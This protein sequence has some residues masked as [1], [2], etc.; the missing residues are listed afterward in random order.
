M[1]TDVDLEGVAGLEA[2]AGTDCL[3]GRA[4]SPSGRGREIGYDDIASSERA[5]IV[6]FIRV[7]EAEYRVRIAAMRSATATTPA[8]T[9]TAT[10]KRRVSGPRCAEW[11][12]F[13][14]AVS[15]ASMARVLAALIE[16]GGHRAPATNGGTDG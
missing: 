7:V 5:L 13:A 1:I 16:R 8:T 4:L 10:P 2:L 11:T 3:R 15:K 14:A 6:A 12:E 9:S